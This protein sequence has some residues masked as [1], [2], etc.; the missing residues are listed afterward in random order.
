VNHFH[1]LIVVALIFTVSSLAQ[2]D[3]EKP[4]PSQKSAAEL[5]SLVFKAYQRNTVASITGPYHLLATFETFTPDGKPAGKGSIERWS[6]A[7]T[8]QKTITRFRD[9]TMTD[10]FVD[11]KHR[12]TD[13]GFD[14][15]IMLYDVY[16]SLFESIPL[17][18]GWD[19]RQLDYKPMQLENISMDC[20][21]YQLPAN[22]PPLPVP[23]KQTICVSPENHD[24]ALTQTQFLNIRYSDFTPFQEKSIPHTISIATGPVIRASVHLQQLDE[25]M[26]E[27]AAMLPPADASPV[28]PAPDW[29][30]TTREEDRP[31]HRVEP[32]YT[33]HMKSAH[34]EGP[35]AVLVLR[36]RS[37]K[38]KD[39]ESAEG[40]P[41][42]LTQIVI[43]AVKNWTYA[44]L[45]REDKPV[46]TISEV[47]FD[48]KA[49]K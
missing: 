38:I 34:I 49:H 46:E 44:P 24:L 6:I 21:L 27:D 37:G 2:T 16:E 10:Y 7:P 14:G 9:H 12:Y 42:E 29:V 41:P 23:I 25:S 31:R 36:S 30:D 20:A 45:I 11:D 33:H 40:E 8:R 4:A 22:G 5:K 43:D 17:R 48:F 26:L 32:D 47:S 15:T 19:H 3:T 13:D 39:I 18:Q 1:R 28:S 35:I